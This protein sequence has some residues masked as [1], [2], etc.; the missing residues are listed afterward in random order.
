ML[1]INI[2]EKSYSNEVVLKDLKINIDKPGIYGIIG[3]NGQGKTTLF[4]C[5]LGLESYKGK[6]VLNKEKISL[7]NTAFCPAEPLIYDELTADE[8]C[9]FYCNLLDIPLYQK[10]K[11]LFHLPK[12]KLIKNFSTGMKK[13]VYINAVF[14][15][16]FSLYFLD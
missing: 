15:K 4:K 13:K 12:D 8:F 1:D 16:K 6:S 14:Q 9:K 3:K 11:E 10:D 2:I 5:V 7:Q